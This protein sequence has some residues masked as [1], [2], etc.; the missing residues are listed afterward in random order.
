MAIASLAPAFNRSKEILAEKSARAGFKL[1]PDISEEK[2]ANRKFM[3]IVASVL[4]F[5]FLLTLLFINTLLAQ[6]AFKLAHLKLEAKIV[7]D[8][9]EA[10]ARHIDQV[11]SPQSLARAA[12]ALGMKP[13]ET[14]IFLNLQQVTSPQRSLG[15][16]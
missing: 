6:D 9:R 14:P 7:S 2:Q 11:S 8:Q 15:N 1:V 10:I 13:S 12:S 16:G 5:I 4:G 3:A